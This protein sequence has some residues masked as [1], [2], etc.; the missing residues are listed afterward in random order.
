MAP[1]CIP[2]EQL[3]APLRARG[4]TAPKRRAGPTGR[5]R[6]ARR[7]SSSRAGSCTAASTPRSPSRWPRW[8]PRWPSSPEGKTAWASPTRRASC[9]R[10]P[11]A[12][13]RRGAARRHRGRTT[14]VWDV[15]FTDD[16][17]R[18]CAVTRMTIAVRQRRRDF[19]PLR[20]RATA[21]SRASRAI[22]VARRIDML[23]NAVPSR[24]VR[25]AAGA[26]RGVAARAE[27]HAASRRGA[28]PAGAPST[29]RPCIDLTSGSG[30][31]VQPSASPPNV[32]T[33]TRHRWAL[34][35]TPL[36]VRPTGTPRSRMCGAT[37][38]W[39][40]R[41]R[42]DGC[43]RGRRQSVPP[44]SSRTASALAVPERTDSPTPPPGARSTSESSTECHHQFHRSVWFCADLVVRVSS[45]TGGPD[46]A[47][48]TPGAARLRPGARLAAV[49]V[50]DRH[51]PVAP[52]GARA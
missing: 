40:D 4:L 31:G 50:G 3:D 35:I 36:S 10:S 16:A 48:G 19:A 23:R 6:V 25:R 49:A 37:K 32:D 2:S 29:A 11:R 27:P 46:G 38:R 8:P 18:T 22:A 9:A 52:E 20:G 17:G 33:L 21:S 12:R 51:A 41:P 42:H 47:A 14:W 24:S 13:P 44:S 5:S 7:G 34:R 15:D 28:A 45:A 43:R 30:C 1:R 39:Y 26:G